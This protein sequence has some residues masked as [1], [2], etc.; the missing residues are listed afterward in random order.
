MSVRRPVEARARGLRSAATMLGL[1]VV[2]AGCNALPGS[3]E[4]PTGGTTVQAAPPGT[5]NLSVTV[6]VGD[7]TVQ[8]NGPGST[9]GN[10]DVVHLV[11][12]LFDNGSAV[13]S[14]GYLFSGN[15]GTTP[16]SASLESATPSYLVDL[17][18]R[19]GTPGTTPAGTDSGYTITS[20]KADADRFL[21][22]DYGSGQNWSSTS[23]TA[24]FTKIPTPTAAAGAHA[25][26]VF[27]A[28]YDGATPPDNL[29]YAEAAVAP[30]TDPSA[31]NEQAALSLYLSQAILGP[32]GSLDE[33]P[34]L[35]P[36]IPTAT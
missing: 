2:M 31:A 15:A 14:L 16:A 28:A 33:T 12:G 25:Y 3:L 5:L 35:V 19:L 24:V 21:I 27:C 17:E 11:V 30:P 10:N 29:G 13:A 8:F 18:G 36:F 20:D 23:T 34:T 26:L 1:L 7:R 32:G 4:P 9:L 22:R 6:A